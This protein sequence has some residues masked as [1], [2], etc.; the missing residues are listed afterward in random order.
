MSFPNSG[1]TYTNHLIQDYTETTTATNYGQE[2]DTKEESIS[3]FTDSI[4]GPF[5]RYPSWLLPPKYIL[6]KTH[7]GG[8][9]DACQT[10]G[11][12][13]YNNTLDAFEV[14]C[15]SGKRIF[16]KEKVKTTYST[17]IPKRAVHLIRDPFDNIVARLHLKERRW[18]RRDNNAK[19]EERVEIFNK[20]KEGFRAYCEF[21]DTRSFKQER[22][23]GIL[24]NELLQY[25]KQVPCYGEFIAYTEWHNHAV[26]LLEKKDIP[27]LTLF[28]EDYASDWDETVGRLLS[29]LSLSPAKGA[30]AE[31]FIRGKHYNEFYDKEEKLAAMKLIEALSSTE[32]WNL[33]RRYFP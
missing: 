29:F 19:Y 14:A 9:C 16:N 20:T 5:F 30:K 7:C 21:R 24:S 4:D 1:T 18:A 27:V 10:P 2:Q 13:Q 28:Y 3:V 8:E 25:A 22:R 6:T 23:H 32:L 15:R 12:K 26:A 33:L 17:D 31:E 11:S